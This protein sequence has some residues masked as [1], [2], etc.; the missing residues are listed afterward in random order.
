M[1]TLVAPLRR[2]ALTLLSLVA[3]CLAAASQSRITDLKPTVI[4]VSLDGFR[5]DYA[6]KFKTP[7]LLRLAAEGVRA[8][9]MIPSFPTKT[10]PNHYTI[11][12]GLYPEDH[13]I[14]ENNVYDFGTVFTM[15][16]ASEVR[17]PRWWGG[18]PIWVTAEKQGQRAASYFSS[19]Q[20]L[21]SKVSCQ[22]SIAHTMARCPTPSA[23]TR[24]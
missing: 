4:L 11:A 15:S 19:G 17:D 22:A 7:T 12:T 1:K 13:G 24:F 14:V 16:K 18:E 23:L 6:D 21:L 2:G 20:R 8:K 3:L 9:W 5:Y 10:F